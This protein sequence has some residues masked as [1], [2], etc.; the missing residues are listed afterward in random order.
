MPDTWPT[1]PVQHLPPT[2]RVDA[3]D[4]A[5]GIAVLGILVI[6]MPGFA[7][8]WPT[9]LNPD[10][11]GQASRVDLVSFSLAWLFFE[12]KM[13][14]LFTILFGVGMA[15][16]L[17]RR[18]MAA[19]RSAQLRRLAW[20]GVFGY[21]H[22]L[23]FWWGD[24]LFLYAAAGMICLAFAGQPPA[25]LITLGALGIVAFTAYGLLAVGPMLLTVDAVHAGSASPE[26][27]AWL[28]DYMRY[29]EAEI[30]TGL[31]EQML[32][33][34]DQIA[35]R[36]AERPLYPVNA[37]HPA[38]FETVPLMLMG[39]GLGK[40][41]FHAGG[42]SRPVMKAIVG[43][44]IGTGLCWAAAQLVWLLAMDLPLAGS[45]LLPFYL[46]LPGRAAM[47][48]G[49]L[50]AVVLWSQAMMQGVVGRALAAAGRMAFSNYLLCSII[51]TFVLHGWGLGLAARDWSYAQLMG[52]VIAGW[53]VMLAWSQPWL[54]RFGTGP[55]EW[56]WRQLV[57]LT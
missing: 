6:N 24:I 34:A 32:G 13:R 40:A 50:A 30:R 38:S 37:L 46:G 57:R 47:A 48:I 17:Q 45:T 49:Y 12:G 31:A 54:R 41:R 4:L 52:F 27:L 56:V 53:I 44:G 15:V 22:F 2:A 35:R 33:M 42:V 55:L 20:L 14:A 9:V 18:G 43:V 16:F 10:W 29:L 23:V 51:M 25:R 1:A 7:G 26:Q 3:L 21:L 28:N 36:L 11:N 39:M 19:G 5:R 8:P